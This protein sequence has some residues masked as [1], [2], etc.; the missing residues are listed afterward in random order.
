MFIAI[1]IYIFGSYKLYKF[2][3]LWFR[4]LENHQVN[5][6]LLSENDYTNQRRKDVCQE[7]LDLEAEGYYVVSIDES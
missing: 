7:I 2:S 5:V 3:N 4:W 6:G 1:G